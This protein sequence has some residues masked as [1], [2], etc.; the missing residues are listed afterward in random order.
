MKG[1]RLEAR[2]FH[3]LAIFDFSLPETNLRFIIKTVAA[4]D[5]YFINGQG[6]ILT[7]GRRK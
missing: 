7:Y 2:A 1:T 3:L 6:R 4:S 5:K